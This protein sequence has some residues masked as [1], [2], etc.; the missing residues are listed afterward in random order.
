[1]ILGPVV[2]LANLFL[3]STDI[4]YKKHLRKWKRNMFIKAN[5]NGVVVK[6]EGEVED[7]SVPNGEH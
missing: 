6:T 7:E 1:M 2:N 3:R 5:G 4:S